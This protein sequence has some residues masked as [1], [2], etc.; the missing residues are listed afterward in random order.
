[1]KMLKNRELMLDLMWEFI[2]SF[3]IA[4]A[5]YNFALNAKFPMTGFSGI[6]FIFYRLFGAPIGIS[7]ILLNIPV[8]FVCYRLIGRGFMQRSLRCMVINSIMIDYVAPLF[9]LY[10]GDRLLAALVTG[11]LGGIGYAVIYMRQSSTGGSDFLIMAAK[12][13]RPHIKLGTIAFLSDILIILAGGIIFRDMDGIIYG[14]IINLLFAVVVDKVMTGINSGKTALIVTKEGEKICDLID[15]CCQRG[16]TILNGRGG[17]KKDDKQV[18]LVACSSKEMYLIEKQMK[19]E[20]EEFFMIVMDA[21][22]IHGEG[23]R[24][25]K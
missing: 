1:M 16:S 21:T 17:Y 7:T 18:V 12:A 13:L 19:L 5:L 11:V 23:F 15:A 25:I 22:E 2:G 4:I 24:V 20:Q 6:A 3:L 9:P 10:H 8:A 14:M